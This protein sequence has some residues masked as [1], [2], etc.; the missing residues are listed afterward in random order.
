MKAV[1]ITEFGAPD[2]LK[3]AERPMPEP[4][5]GEVLIKV[6]ASGINRPDVFQRKGAY[7]PPQGASDLPGL[8]VAGEIVGGALDA[9]HNPFGLKKGDRVCALLAGGGY[10]EYAAAPLAQC[11]PVPKGLT[12]IEAASLPETFFTVWSNVFDRAKLG[13]GEGGANE[14]FMVQGGSSG[15]GV[16]AIQI[17]HA[18]GFRVFATA[19]SD[20]KCR[21]CEELG[22]ERAINYKTED[23][24]E[25]V[26]SLTNDRGVDVIL[27]M[28]AGSYVPRELTALASGGR[29]VLI[30]LLGGA[31]AEVNLND[32]LRRRL[33]ITGSTLRPQPV[34]FK[35]RIA[36]NLKEH[37][38]PHL[39]AGRIKPVVHR[40][41]PAAQAAD[42]HAL[43]ESSTHVG[44]IVLNWG[45]D[46]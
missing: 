14:T 40:V 37:V 7:A 29:L 28:V 43:M 30:A 4:K 39:E 12:D 42:A 45:A 27:D 17:A 15:I 1:E 18:L 36:A 20:D 6:A 21:A 13:T 16:T 44:K 41:F 9:Q 10:A 11:L 25:V 32:I 34:E 23:F 46:V 3:L 38:W 22:A 24:V 35:A 2:V 31:K 8:E 5:A 26:K 19:G 33:T